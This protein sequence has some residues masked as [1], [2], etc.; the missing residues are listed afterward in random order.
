MK[1]I[2]P[3]EILWPTKADP[4]Y[5]PTD[6]VE[7]EASE[8]LVEEEVDGCRTI[9]RFLGKKKFQEPTAP[10]N[11][12]RSGGHLAPVGM[13]ALAHLIGNKD[14][15]SW[16]YLGQ[17]AA[18]TC[19]LGP[20]SAFD[21]HAAG[22]LHGFWSV[23]GA[24]RSDDAKKLRAY[25]DYMKTFLILSECHNG[26]LY[27]QPWGRDRA[28]CNSDPTYG[29]RILPTATGAILLALQKKR[30]LITGADGGIS[31][32]AETSS[33]SPVAAPAAD[34]GTPVPAVRAPRTMSADKLAALDKALLGVLVGLSDAK[35]LKQVPMAISKTRSKVWLAEA[36]KEGDLTFQLVG[37]MEKASFK[38]SELAGSDHAT[39][40]LLVASLKPTSSDAQAMA[41]VYMESAGRTKESEDYYRKAGEESAKK[42]Q[43][44]FD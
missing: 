19:A 12:S 24:A 2:G 33:E 13:G 14:N 8:N 34:Q 44:L 41:G 40:S 10:Y 4:R 31:A 22:N 36:T 30:L 43:K 3:Y 35:E 1:D 11:T 37:G 26:G 15:K 16:T 42:L 9:R 7:K 28:G 17:H 21:G 27:L 18:N 38:F 6:W 23:L 20:G 29:P 39:L 25:F 32:P 5:K